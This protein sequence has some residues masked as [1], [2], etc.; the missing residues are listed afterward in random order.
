MK[1]NGFLTFC[2]AM[3][4][5]CGQMYQGYMKR[6]LSLLLWFCAVIALA[7]LTRIYIILLL[8]IAIWAYSFFD[9]F[10][11]RSLSAEQRAAF[12]DSYLP[13]GA[14]QN[15][16]T[17]RRWTGNGRM[18]K[19]AGWVCIGVGVLILMGNLWDMFIY[20]LWNAFP[21]VAEVVERLPA[22][23]IAALVILLGLRI[24]K[25]GGFL[26][27]KAGGEN[28]AAPPAPAPAPRYSEDDDPMFAAPQPFAPPAPGE[29]TEPTP[30]GDEKDE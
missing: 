1:K 4:P 22:L 21:F 24:M 7:S 15:S 10:N 5:G 16:E 29:A 8:L 19:I 17:V 18:A 27:G 30:E 11:I 25:S 23:V 26:Q 28:A 14:W 9:A 12:A 3:V 6:G 20:R 2:C 13:G